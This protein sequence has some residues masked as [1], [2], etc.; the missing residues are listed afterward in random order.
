MNLRLAAWAASAGAVAA[1]SPA[2]GAYDIQAPLSCAAPGL[3]IV[4][5]SSNYRVPKGAAVT[6][7]ISSGTLRQ[8]VR[9]TLDSVLPIGAKATFEVLQ[10]KQAGATSTCTATATWRTF[11]DVY[12]HP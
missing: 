3:I 7:L 12:V 11:R 5:N 4:T 6:V 10:V 2:L 8:T 9:Q 1:A